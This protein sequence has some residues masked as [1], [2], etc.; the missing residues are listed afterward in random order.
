MTPALLGDDTLLTAEEAAKL[1]GVS[2]SMFRRFL[3]PAVSLGP[4]TL[5]WRLGTLR[6]WVR[7]REAAA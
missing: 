5:R 4:R 7:R 3:I 2:V 6:Q 1:L